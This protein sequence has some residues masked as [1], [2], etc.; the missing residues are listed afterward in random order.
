MAKSCSVN[1]ASRCIALFKAQRATI[2]IT[3]SEAD[4]YD[5]FTDVGATE[6][7]ES[8]LGVIKESFQEAEY[9]VD[10][11]SEKDSHLGQARRS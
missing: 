6:I 8:L 2:S 10:T 5:S 1:V 9:E 4:S 7:E 3:E 11:E